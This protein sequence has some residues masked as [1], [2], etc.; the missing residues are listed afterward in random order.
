[1]ERTLCKSSQK[2]KTLKKICNTLEFIEMWLSHSVNI[3]CNVTTPEQVMMEDQLCQVGRD[4]SMLAEVENTHS[5]RQ[6]PEPQCDISC[7]SVASQV[8][9][10]TPQFNTLTGDSTKNREVLFEQWAFKVKNVMHSHTEG[11]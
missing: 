6:M 1:M 8:V 9:G 5:P 10:K 11:T 7:H 3:G 4:E 2:M